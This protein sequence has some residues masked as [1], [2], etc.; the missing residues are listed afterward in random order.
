MLKGMRLLSLLG[1]GPVAWYLQSTARPQPCYDCN[2]ND[3]DDDDGDDDD[4]D[5]D[6]DPLTTLA[7]HF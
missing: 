1:I 2:N 3:D 7:S 4:N 5:D 6:D